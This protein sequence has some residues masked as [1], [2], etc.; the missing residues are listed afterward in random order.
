MKLILVINPGSTSTKIGVFED[1]KVSTC[2]RT[3]IPKNVYSDAKIQ[4]FLQNQK[5]FLEK[6]KNNYQNAIC[7]LH[8]ATSFA[9]I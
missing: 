1:E 7:I 6:D 8:S 9:R 5:L 3:E 2:T 4:H